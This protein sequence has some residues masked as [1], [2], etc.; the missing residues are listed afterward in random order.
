MPM[1]MDIVVDID[2][3]LMLLVEKFTE[4]STGLRSLTKPLKEV[5]KTVVAPALQHNFAVEGPGWEKLS[6]VTIAKK[7]HDMILMETGNLYKKAGQLNIWK[8]DGGY[9]TGEASAYIDNLG[10]PKPSGAEP[11]GFVQNAGYPPHN[12]P[13]RQW[14][15]LDGTA[16]DEIEVAFS[17]W[18]NAVVEAT[19]M[20]PIVGGSGGGILAAIAVGITGDTI[21]AS[22]GLGGFN[23][24]GGVMA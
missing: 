6:A 24:F 2:P 15:I 1:S 23:S 22:G 16:V 9:S 14:A 21:L 5:I 18:V 12:L 3:P 17:L 11:Y 10:G 4:C 7:G 19:I 13:Q 8:I 20:A